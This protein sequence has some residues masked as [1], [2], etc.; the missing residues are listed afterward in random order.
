MTTSPDRYTRM[1]ET[2]WTDHHPADNPTLD[3]RQAM[4]ETASREIR[5]EIEQ[6]Q[7]ELQANLAPSADY[8]SQVAAIRQTQR[9]A[10]EVVLANWFP[11]DLPE[12]PTTTPA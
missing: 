6:T 5:N 8:L 1:A 9:Q 4:F 10:E 7:A 12:H 3:D 2:W 11:A